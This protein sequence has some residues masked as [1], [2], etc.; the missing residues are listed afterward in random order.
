M[1]AWAFPY[2]ALLRC[3][4]RVTTATQYEAI[5]QAVTFTG[6]RQ[7]LGDFDRSPL[8]VL[9]TTKI[10]A[11]HSKPLETEIKFT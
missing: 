9:Q 5:H 2:I 10:T 7:T 8:F 3:R 6:D 1:A 11:D 4:R